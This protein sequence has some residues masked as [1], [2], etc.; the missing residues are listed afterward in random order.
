[1]RPDRALSAITS[2]IVRSCD[3][4]AVLLFGS[5]AKGQET[6]ESDLDLLVICCPRWSMA[7]QRQEVRE[8]LR[9]F[10][11]AIDVHMVTR[12]DVAR[13]SSNPYGFLS[14]AMSSGVVLYER[15][16]RR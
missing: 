11:I 1:V 12:E 4:E 2:L 7:G 10:P 13:E 5:Y 3:P 8:L 14:S 6:L 15:T 16:T 9:R